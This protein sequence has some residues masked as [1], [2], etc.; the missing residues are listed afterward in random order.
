MGGLRV[1]GGIGGGGEG[2]GHGAFLGFRDGREHS[3]DG[4]VSVLVG[5]L[6]GDKRS[7]GNAYSLLDGRSRDVAA[8]H[9][10]ISLP[11]A[12]SCLHLMA[13]GVRPGSL[14][15][16]HDWP[17]SNGTGCRLSCSWRRSGYIVWR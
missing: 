11:P 5:W 8:G 6:V 15:L 2:C 9:G 13:Y 10:F 4:G 12:V 17:E 3:T 1:E 16:R 7:D 14:S